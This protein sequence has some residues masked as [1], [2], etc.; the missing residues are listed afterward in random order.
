MTSP[1]ALVALALTAQ[2]GDEDYRLPAVVEIL[3]IIVVAGAFFALF[4][5]NRRRGERRR[6]E[7]EQAQR[8]LEG[9]AD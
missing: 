6:A 1:L 2:A 8:E 5:S 9:D 4:E 7:L 3:I